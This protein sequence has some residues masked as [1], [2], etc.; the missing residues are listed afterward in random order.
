MSGTSFPLRQQ[1]AVL[2]ETSRVIVQR[3]R[4]SH[5]WID[6]EFADRVEIW[7]ADTSSD[8]LLVS[9]CDRK[10]IEKQWRIG[11]CLFADIEAMS[12]CQAND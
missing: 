9:G 11:D 12:D 7:L 3:L 6:N 4:H 5:R 8:P 10:A 1:F 2:L